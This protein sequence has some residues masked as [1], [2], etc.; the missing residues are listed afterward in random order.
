V[1]TDEVLSLILRFVN[2]N[3]N[4]VDV[5]WDGRMKPRLLF[6]PYSEDSEQKKMTAHYFLLVASLLEDRVVGFSENSRRLLIYLHEKLGKRLFEIGKPH[7]F[8]EEIVKSEF[9]SDLGP[10]RQVIPEV[11]TSV[12]DFVK[13]R[14]QKDL[15][16]YTR[17]F[18]CPK[19]FVEDVA[20]NTRRM[21]DPYKDKIWTYLRW[22]VRPK[23]DLG[24]LGHFS[25]EDLQVPLTRENANVAA[26]LG[27]ISSAGPYLWND[28]STATKARERITNFAIRLFPRDPAK[29]DYPFF[30]L[31]RWLK[32]KNLNRNTL[33]EAL[34]FFDHMHKVT[35]QPHA[36]YQKLGRYKSG[37]EK[38]TAVTL[39]KMGISYGY[40]SI[41]FPLPGDTY[42]PDFILDKSV[43]GRRI[44]LEPH[45]EMTPRQVWKYSLFKRTY[46]HEFLLI[47]VLKNDLIPFYHEHN[48]LSDTI[49]DDAWPIEFIDLLAEKIRTGTYDQQSPS[50]GL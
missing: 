38:K 36:Y 44:I 11:L 23:P 13:N 37:W 33:K 25:Q 22:M 47:L 19:D 9:Y 17:R 6:N 43:H 16:E 46:G 8:E 4:F 29:V 49:C 48:L 18:G 34:E 41:S 28:R 15:V 26:S 5:Q 35:G 45:Y 50:A 3:S 21:D 32:Q 30:L 20:Q 27:V 24:I 12:N 39:S 10:L 14:A 42:T 40:E 7:L 31:G 2:L 1:A